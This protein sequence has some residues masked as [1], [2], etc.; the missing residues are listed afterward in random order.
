MI[1]DSVVSLTKGDKKNLYKMPR[2]KEDE[3]PFSKAK[4]KAP[5][6]STF[7]GYGPIADPCPAPSCDTTAIRT[8]EANGFP[9]HSADSITSLYQTMFL[10][11]Q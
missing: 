1:A 4:A 8:E 6:N 11:D 2:S 7:I 3:A 5:E 10:G 9:D